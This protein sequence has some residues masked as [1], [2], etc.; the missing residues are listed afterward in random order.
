MV[1]L[2][3]GGKVDVILFLPKEE[4]HRVNDVTGGQILQLFMTD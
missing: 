2:S 4:Q 3:S 1:N